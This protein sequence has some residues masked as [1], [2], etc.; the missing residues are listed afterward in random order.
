MLR[1]LKK[2]E[3][4][5]IVK[6]LCNSGLSVTITLNPVNWQWVPDVGVYAK[7]HEWPD[8]H[9]WSC[10]ANWLCISIGIWIDDGSW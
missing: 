5:N 7:N 3:M 1:N 10:N 4:T 8:I 2:L 9:W 6:W